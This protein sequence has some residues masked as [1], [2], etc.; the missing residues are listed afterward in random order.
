MPVILANT[1]NTITEKMNPTAK[2]STT[3]GSTLKPCA[4]SVN[5]FNMVAEEPPAPAALVDKGNWLASLVFLSAAFFLLAA[6]LN[7]PGAT[8]DDDW[9]LVLTFGGFACYGAL[10]RG[11]Q[12]TIMLVD[13]KWVRCSEY[14]SLVFRRGRAVTCVDSPAQISLGCGGATCGGGKKKKE[15]IVFCFCSVLGPSPKFPLRLRLPSLRL[16]SCVCVSIT[17]GVPHPL[18]PTSPHYCGKY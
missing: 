15:K 7:P 4:S 5:N 2:K 13:N 17:F 9:A 8:A 11:K 6:L 10:P 3:N 12:H 1:C 16:C 18:D 14:T